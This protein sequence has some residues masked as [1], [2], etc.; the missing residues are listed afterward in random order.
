VAG[1]ARGRHGRVTPGL[2]FGHAAIIVVAGMWAGMVNT[3]VGS[4]TLVT[5]VRE[6]CSC[7][8]ARRLPL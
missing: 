6:Q 2:D 7:F 3:I 5:F 1:D 4:W 8:L